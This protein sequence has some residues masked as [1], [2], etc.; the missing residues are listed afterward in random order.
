MVSI[1]IIRR[2]IKSTQNIAQITKAMEMVAASKM[3]K[4]QQAAVLGKP[5]AERIYLATKE[6]ASRTDKK[7]HP[8]LSL[9]NPTGGQLVIL[10][11]TNKGLCGGL[12][13][14]LFRNT[15][16]WFT[17]LAHT[18]YI[19]IGKKGENFVVKTGRHLVADFSQ[20]LPF[21]ENVAAVTK[22]AVDGFIT[23]LYK[24]VYLV[25]NMFMN[26]LKHT[27]DKKLLLPLS[28]FEGKEEFQEMK[29]AEFKVEPSA[30][31]IL[32]NLLPHYLESQIRTA[33]LEAEASEHSARMMAMKNAT[34]AA[35]DLMDALTLMFNKARQEKITYE[36]ADMVTARMTTE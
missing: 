31:D 17:D 16:S 3:K 34:D 28:V 27:P 1:K 33:I 13:T 29:F 12:N 6:L 8:L 22:L 19:S 14:N 20:K 15:A 7:L 21:T 11:S 18:E 23:G 36:I 5:Y 25:Y 32:E 10:I 30:T 24:E 26:A 4:A 2:R 9:G 35:M